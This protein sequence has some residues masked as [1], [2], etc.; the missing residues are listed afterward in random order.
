MHS[1]QL[2]QSQPGWEKLNK[3]KDRNRKNDWSQEAFSP[4][5]VQTGGIDHD[6]VVVITRE[7]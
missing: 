1:V 3:T 6:S 5:D 2:Q 4:A 7:I